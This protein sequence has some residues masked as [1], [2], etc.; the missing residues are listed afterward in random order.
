LSLGADEMAVVELVVTGIFA[1]LHMMPSHERRQC[2][3]LSWP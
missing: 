3:R 2:V 1:V